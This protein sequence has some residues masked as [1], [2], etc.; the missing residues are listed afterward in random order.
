MIRSET[1]TLR[2]VLVHRP[3]LELERLTPVNKDELLFD[4][5]VWV[6][7]AAEEHDALARVLRSRGADVLYVESL[8]EEVLSD[9]E[10]ARA[11]I[12]EQIPDELCGRR[13]A[14]TVRA[15]LFEVPPSRLVEHL[16]G[17]VTF[18]D[19]GTDR[20]LVA[21]L[22]GPPCARKIAG[23]IS[24]SVCRCPLG[25]STLRTRDRRP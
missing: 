17:G 2:A 20:G 12:T 7:K 16:I 1:E 6:D 21:A 19:V 24:V 22:H 13:L 3:G 14:Q 11:A 25:L 23:G 10:L 9:E 8:L 5:L 4:E 18:G 15:Y